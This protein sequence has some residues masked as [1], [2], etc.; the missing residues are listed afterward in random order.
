MI[1]KTDLPVHQDLRFMIGATVRPQYGS[2]RWAF[3]KNNNPIPGVVI[4]VHMPNTE[5]KCLICDF[6]GETAY[7]SLCELDVLVSATDIVPPQLCF[8]DV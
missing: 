2:E 1:K 3:A 4:G 5:W 7:L 8:G 6:N